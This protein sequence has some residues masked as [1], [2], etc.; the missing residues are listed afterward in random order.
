MHADASSSAGLRRV[1]E[2]VLAVMTAAAAL[3]VFLALQ[4]APL[5][6]DEVFHFERIE[7]LLRGTMRLQDWGVMLPGYHLFIAGMLRLSGFAS[8]PAAR[9]VT[10]LVSVA[11]CAAAFSVAFSLDRKS[12]LLRTLQV[13]TLP[14]L[15]PFFPL[16]YTDT[17]SLCILL[18]ATFAALRGWA[19]LSGV[20]LLAAVGVRQ[21]NVL[22]VPLIF[23][24]VLGRETTW[25]IVPTELSEWLHESAARLRA[26][27]SRSVFVRVSLPFLLPVAAFVTFV[28]VT[29]RA[30]LNPV[31]AASHPFPSFS[32]GNVFTA[33]SIFA[34]L[35]LPLVCAR[36]RSIAELLVRRRWVLIGI[37]ALFFLF[38]IGF[39]VNHPANSD[40]AYFR[41]AV[42][43]AAAAG[44]LPGLLFFLASALALL[45]M[46]VTPLMRRSF[47]LLY[48]LALLYLGGSWLI[49]IRYAIV[50]L[51][52][53]LLFRKALSWRMELLQLL[54]NFVLCLWVFL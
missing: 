48:P 30:S 5:V 16:L 18:F 39:R 2:I 38:F 4:H 26:H 41:D 51:V 50:P 46:I 21:N 31:L 45:T 25:Q 24:I 47:V 12:A 33:L 27:R 36:V 49:D 32:L 10:F 11:C 6:F 23:A 15:L 54:F 17:L 8:V 42:L 1:I 29:G 22:W 37:A 19:L 35:F 44:G 34:A 40:P 43:L 13:A 9:F 28:L 53:F 7:G 20:L 14:I 52:L 3:Q